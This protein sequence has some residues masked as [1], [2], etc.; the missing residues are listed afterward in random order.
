[1]I[2]DDWITKIGSLNR[3]ELAAAFGVN[4]KT[5][6]RWFQSGLIRNDDGT[7]SLPESI[8]WA[9]DRGKGAE[10]ISDEPDEAK[11]WLTEFRKERAIRA[12]L[13][14]ETI[15]GRLF[16]RE[17]VTAAWC[18]RYSH[19]K[20]HLLSWSKRLPGRL[21]G[22]NERELGEILEDETVFLLSLLSRPGDFCNLDSEDSTDE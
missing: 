10:P 15:E 13:E 1:M 4:P 8:T 11:R 21:Q 5:I 7:Y 14:R 2:L 19:F 3:L 18:N 22:L 17:D 16:P 9:I 12:R 20:R 6:T